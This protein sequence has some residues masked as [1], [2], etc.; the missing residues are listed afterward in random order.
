M[1]INDNPTRT[2]TVRV[3]FENIAYPLRSVPFREIS[4]AW[5]V[6]FCK[7]P[8]ESNDA[9]KR[10]QMNPAKDGAAFGPI[11]KS[12]RSG[13]VPQISREDGSIKTEPD[14]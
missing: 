5:A 11:M 6:P 10:A 2:S 1:E 14:G 12:C 9:L 7:V 13:F 3:L 4:F 8:K